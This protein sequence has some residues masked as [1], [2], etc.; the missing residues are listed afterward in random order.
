MAW[1][2]NVCITDV[3]GQALPSSHGE[4]DGFVPVD[5]GIHTLRPLPRGSVYSVATC[6]RFVGLGVRHR[7]AASIV[8]TNTP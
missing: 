2:A 3:G 4:N 5:T 7:F 8:W 6:I 1:E